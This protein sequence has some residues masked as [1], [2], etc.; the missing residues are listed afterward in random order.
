MLIE[1]QVCSYEQAIKFKDLGVLQLSTWYW[2]KMREPSAGERLQ[3]YFKPDQ[4]VDNTTVETRFAAYGSAE[5]G[6]FLQ[7]YSGIG[8]SFYSAP[9]GGW[10]HT[11][12]VNDNPL[13]IMQWYDTE[14]QARAGMLIYLIENSHINIQ[15]LNKIV[16][17]GLPV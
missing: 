4:P 15:E 1:D 3:V 10:A 17:S 12:S 14:T 5:L 11:C 9:Q 7:L 13:P 2:E 6:V 8:H 16:F